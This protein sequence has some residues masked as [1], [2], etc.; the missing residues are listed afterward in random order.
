MHYASVYEYTILDQVY[1]D[2]PAPSD[3]REYEEYHDH[4]PDSIGTYRSRAAHDSVALL[5]PQRI[6]PLRIHLSIYSRPV[7]YDLLTSV[8][9]FVICFL[10]LGIA[11]P[12]AEVLSEECLDRTEL[13]LVRLYIEFLDFTFYLSLFEN[14]P[15]SFFEQIFVMKNICTFEAMLLGYPAHVS[16]I[17]RESS[18]LIWYY[19]ECLCETKC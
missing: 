16:I 13:D 2:F 7:R 18:R 9:Y 15:V 6:E 19:P 5:M 1:T 11:Y 12:Q 3:E 17:L 14:F 10:I 8:I 4:R